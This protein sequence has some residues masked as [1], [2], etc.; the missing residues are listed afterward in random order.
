[1]KFNCSRC[2]AEADRPTGH[3]NRQRS[4]GAPLYC[5]R[6]CF[7]LTR[8]KHRSKSEL[9]E[10]KKAYDAEYRNKNLAKITARK[11]AYFQATYDPAKAAVDR[12]KTM[13]RHVEYCRSPEYKAWK[14]DYDKK[15]RAS[16]YGEYADAFLLLQ[17]LDRELDSRAD[18]YERANQK[19]TIN[20][21]IKRKR[22]Y[23]SSLRS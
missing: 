14:R 10:R 8:R 3:I 17:D 21:T 6:K 19:G 5:G 12:K 16:V 2:G 22:A 20:K 7:G 9:I 4:I 13:A 15:L 23:E 18:W 11:A 1:M